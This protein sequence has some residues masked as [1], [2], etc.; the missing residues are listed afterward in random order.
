MSENDEALS[1]KRSPLDDQRPVSEE[2][3]SWVTA[4]GFFLIGVVATVS[5]SIVMWAPF[6]FLYI[7]IV[8]VGWVPFVMAGGIVVG[9]GW[10]FAKLR[11][12][13]FGLIGGAL[14]LYWPL[15]ID[16]YVIG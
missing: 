5:Q 9:L 2:R 13:G 3:V 11:W 14:A 6:I 4:L 7:I 12:Y 16:W 8:L 15:A 1:A 10:R